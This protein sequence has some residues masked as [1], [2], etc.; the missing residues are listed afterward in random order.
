MDSDYKIFLLLGIDHSSK[1]IDGTWMGYIRNINVLHPFLFDTNTK[2]LLYGGAKNGKERTNISSHEIDVG[3]MFTVSGEE[4]GR[5]YE[6]TYEVTAMHKYD[7]DSQLS[8]ERNHFD[9]NVESKEPVHTA[10]HRGRRMRAK[11]ITIQKS[12]WEQVE[13]GM[14]LVQVKQI[15]DKDIWQTPMF[16]GNTWLVN[17]ERDPNPGHGYIITFNE[18]GKVKDKGSFSMSD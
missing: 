18:N 13:N 8:E 7:D 1:V 9:S 17:N 14:T 12:R 16:S 15:F 5:T 10:D 11:P 4:D 2:T 6:S 3:C